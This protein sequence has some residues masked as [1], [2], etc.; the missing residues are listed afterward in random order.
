MV[1]LK[2]D[3]VDISKVDLENL[4]SKLSIIPQDLALFSNTIGFNLD[5]YYKKSQETESMWEALNKD[6]MDGIV[7][8]IG[9]LEALVL[10]GRENFSQG[11]RQLLCIVRALLRDTKL[12]VLD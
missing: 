11:Q 7:K 4:R 8:E 9:G 6:K 1:T 10:E 3:G 5:P 2:I 12:L